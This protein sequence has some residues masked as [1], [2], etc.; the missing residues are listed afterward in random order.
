[1][2]LTLGPGTIPTPWNPTTMAQATASLGYTVSA[3]GCCANAMW[4]NQD[5]RQCFTDSSSGTSLITFGSCINRGYEGRPVAN[6]LP[7]F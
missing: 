3:G 4:C 5:T 1:M 7:L 6:C 2:G